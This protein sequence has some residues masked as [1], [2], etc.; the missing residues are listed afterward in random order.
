[1]SFVRPTLSALITRVRGDIQSRL[2]GADAALRHAVLKVLGAVVAGVASS[3]YGYLDW[4]ARQLMPDTAEAEYLARWAAIW[5]KDRKAATAATATATA[6]GTNDAVILA[7]TEAQRVDG[8]VYTVLEDVTIAAG[9]ASLSIAAA[10]AGTAGSLEIGTTLTLSSAIA[11]VNA[12]ITVTSAVAGTEE[13]IDASLL[14]RLL[15]RIR[16]PPQGGAAHDYV[17]WALEQAGV[18]R[19]WAWGGWMGVGTVGLTFVMDDRD[20]I[21]PLEA[22]VTAVQAALDLLRPVTA[23]LYVFA[24]TPNSIEFQLR[25]S[26]DTSEIRTA[27]EAELADFFARE[28][29]PGGTLYLSRISEAISLAEGEFQHTIVAPGGDPTSAAYELPQLGTVTWL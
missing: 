6:T 4:L 1:M 23:T 14:A 20:D 5:G 28:A 8:A 18:T 26:P 16:T 7:G 22:D 10:E 12:T 3:L 2:K 25:I 24:P 29:E 19:A 21:I 27:V 11:G 17:T 9:T 13:E 15:D